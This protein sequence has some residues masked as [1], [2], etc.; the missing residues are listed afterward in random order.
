M[1]PGTAQPGAS[2]SHWLDDCEWSWTGSLAS[3]ALD[4]PAGPGSVQA[5]EEAAAHR[6]GRL[7][8]HRDALGFLCP[9][10]RPTRP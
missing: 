6:A 2:I 1:S 4:H 8:A 5:P 7:R 9:V 3:W 10:L